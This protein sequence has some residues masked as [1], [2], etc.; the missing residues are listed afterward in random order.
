MPLPYRSNFHFLKICTNGI[1]FRH[2]NADT[3]EFTQQKQP[4]TA[5][6]ENWW[7]GRDHYKCREMPRSSMKFFAAVVALLCSVV[8]AET[9]EEVAFSTPE[10]KVFWDRFLRSGGGGGGD[11]SVPMSPRTPP[12][13]TPVVAP[14]RP[15]VSPPVVAP[16]QPPPTSPV[17]IPLQPPVASPIP[18]P[19]A[20]PLQP[21]V[22]APVAVPLQSP[23]TPPVVERQIENAAAA[24]LKCF[25]LLDDS[26]ANGSMTQDEYLEFLKVMSDGMI[27]ISEFEDLPDMYMMIFFTAACSNS[28]C[29]PGNVPQ[30]EIGNI[31]DPNDTIQFMCQEILKFTATTADTILEYTIRYSTSTIEEDEL[32]TCFSTALVNI[33]LK[34]LANC[35]QLTEIE[36]NPGSKRRMTRRQESVHRNLQALGSAMTDENSKC[37][38]YI[39][40]SVEKL[41]ELRKSEPLYS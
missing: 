32:A 37:D 2:Q 5:I 12:I 8:V 14:F 15:P 27:N 3:A 28:D 16:L 10:D 25:T 6:R 4:W 35:P 22:V 19:V 23:V 26:S 1:L 9:V 38:Y 36:V 11:L 7:F 30:I 29:S 18:S 21:P 20:D 34:E 41:T 13:P 17:A 33:L 39:E 31:D 40:S 24:F